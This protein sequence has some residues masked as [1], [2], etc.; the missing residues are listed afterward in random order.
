[1]GNKE[2]EK[3]IRDN[4]THWSRLQLQSQMNNCLHSK[5][6]QVDPSVWHSVKLVREKRQTRRVEQK[7][8]SCEQDEEGDCDKPCG[9]QYKSYEIGDN[10][11]RRNFEL[12]ARKVILPIF[13]NSMPSS[14][15]TAE[16]VWS[17]NSS[18]GHVLSKTGPSDDA[19]SFTTS[20][21]PDGTLLRTSF[22]S[23]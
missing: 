8:T 2:H 14:L 22:N 3:I 17:K 13:N 20:Y 19:Q 21:Y 23:W 1:M 9:D 11:Q 6:L 10:V 5:S 15:S 7:D 16:Q 18:V 4:L 12:S